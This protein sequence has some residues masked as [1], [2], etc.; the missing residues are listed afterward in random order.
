V[1]LIG[2]LTSRRSSSLSLKGLAAGSGA[3]AIPPGM[4]SWKAAKNLGLPQ[5]TAPNMLCF[6]YCL[7]FASVHDSGRLFVRANS[8]V[9]PTASAP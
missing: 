6:F 2:L 5:G 9:G 1:Q 3:Y 7:R 4:S 8:I